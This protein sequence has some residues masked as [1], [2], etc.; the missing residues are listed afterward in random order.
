MGSPDPSRESIQRNGYTIICGMV[1][2]NPVQSVRCKSFLWGAVNS[3]VVGSSADIST[4]ELQQGSETSTTARKLKKIATARIRT[5]KPVAKTQQGL[6]VYYSVIHL[7]HLPGLA[8]RTLES[9]VISHGG[10]Q[11][12]I[13]VLRKIDGTLIASAP[14]A[15]VRSIFL[16]SGRHPK[17]KERT[18]VTSVKHVAKRLIRRR[19]NDSNHLRVQYLCIYVW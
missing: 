3:V 13:P 10:Y 7:S 18:W 15:S 1:K 2:S 4:L 16:W 19:D 14:S 12:C 5:V 8:V 11:S 6:K 9:G 17:P